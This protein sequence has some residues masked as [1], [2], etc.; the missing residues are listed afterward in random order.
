MVSKIIKQEYLSPGASSVV[1][2][3]DIVQIVNAVELCEKV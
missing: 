2:K 3:I 1:G